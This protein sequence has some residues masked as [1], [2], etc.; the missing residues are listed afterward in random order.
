MWQ[1]AQNGFTP[2]FVDIDRRTLGINPQQVIDR[3]TPRTRAVLAIHI[4]GYNALTT[5]LIAELDRRGIALLE[6]AC[7][8]TA[9]PCM[10]A[11]SDPLGLCPTSRSTLPTT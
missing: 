9:P 3:I 5:E 6:D 1:P 7:E 4:L 8:T 2:V 11:R 10:D